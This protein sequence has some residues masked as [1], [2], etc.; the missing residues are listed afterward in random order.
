MHMFKPSII[1]SLIILLSFGF[2]AELVPAESYAASEPSVDTS[3]QAQIPAGEYTL[4]KAHA[5]LIFRVS[6]MGFSQYTASFSHFDVKMQFDPRHPEASMVEAVIDPASLDLIN[7]PEGFTKALLGKQWLDAASYPQITFISNKVELTGNHTAK[8]YGDFTLHGVTRP[9]VLDVTF[10]G[11]Y[12]GIPMDPH[13]RIGFSAHGRFKRS[14][15]GITYG[16]PA[17]G[18]HM[19][20][21]DEVEVIIEAE[22]S[23]PPSA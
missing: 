21:G 7:P 16:I 19:G 4:D 1:I 9:L 2:F 10:N 22:L 18:S 13:A 12:A 5:S 23:G 6:H 8:V 14:D 17:P 15:Y 11:G 3:S 20:V